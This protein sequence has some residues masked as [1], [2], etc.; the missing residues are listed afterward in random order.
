MPFEH[1]YYFNLKTLR[2]MLW[3][4]GFR[5][6]TVKFENFDVGRGLSMSGQ[7]DYVKILLWRL[8]PGKLQRLARLTRGG[9]TLVVYAE[10]KCS[11]QPV[12]DHL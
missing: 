8:G 10:R 3:K 2:K 9:G 12:A 11:G 1:L 5:V 7:P 6:R 4:V